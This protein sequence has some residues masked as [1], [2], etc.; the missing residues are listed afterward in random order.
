MYICRNLY[1]A[2]VEIESQTRSNHK[3]TIQWNNYTQYLQC[4]CTGYQ[5]HGKCKHIK[6]AYSQLDCI[7]IG[8][9]LG[10]AEGIRVCP[11]CAS[12]VYVID[13][14]FK[15]ALS[16]TYSMKDGSVIVTRGEEMFCILDTRTEDRVQMIHDL[17]TKED[18]S[19]IREGYESIDRDALLKQFNILSLVV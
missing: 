4:T 10:Y 9:K 5:I 18:V 12:P 7:W 1:E 19:S 14:R 3:Y 15:D 17:V 11:I 8:T 16:T 13:D 6:E 2:N